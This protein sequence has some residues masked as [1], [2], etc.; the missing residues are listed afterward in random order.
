L[1]QGIEKM[2]AVIINTDNVGN[3]VVRILSGSTFQEGIAPTL[4]ALRKS[5]DVL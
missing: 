5:A 2:G 4:L 3:P 1:G